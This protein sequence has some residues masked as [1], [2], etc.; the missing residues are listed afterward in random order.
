[1]KTKD[2]L[3]GQ[4][5]TVLDRIGELESRLDQINGAIARLE[6]EAE[7]APDESEQLQ[8]FHAEG[9]LP[10]TRTWQFVRGQIEGIK[11]RQVEISQRLEELKAEHAQLLNQI[12][13]YPI[14]VVLAEN[15]TPLCS[16]CGVNCTC[17][18]RG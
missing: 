9:T 14:Q 2:Y 18:L 12:E 4:A 17:G 10:T 13:N 7:T 5:A 6:K 11:S 15:G 8:L 3:A 16:Q 1:M